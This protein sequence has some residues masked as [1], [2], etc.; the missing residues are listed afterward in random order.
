M[1]YQYI[2]IRT[3]K[4]ILRVTIPVVGEDADKVDLSYIVNGDVRWYSLSG[5]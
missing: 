5:K 2:P 3:S 1:R 4:F